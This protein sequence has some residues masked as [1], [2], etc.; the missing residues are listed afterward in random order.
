[1]G[2]MVRCGARS[3]A[4]A[5]SCLVT[6]AADAQTVTTY[7]YDTQGRVTK[8]DHPGSPQ[9]HFSYDRADNRVEVTGGT[10]NRP[11][12]AIWDNV[13]LDDRYQS[14][15]MNPAA[16]GSDPENH[17]LVV[18]WISPVE[19]YHQYGQVVATATLRA[20]GLVAITSVRSGQASFTY[21]VEDGRD[22]VATG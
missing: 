19:S 16:N 8:V 11:P 2:I 1:M 14:S 17:P 7:T 9:R 13:V 12:T 10:P 15:I 6:G 5:L 4:I 21:R 3:S 22:G 18:A 20:D